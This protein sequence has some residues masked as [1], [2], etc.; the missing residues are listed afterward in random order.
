MVCYTIAST[1]SWSHFQFEKTWSWPNS[2]YY[3]DIHPE[4]ILTK[5]K[6]NIRRTSEN[7]IKIRSRYL[8][9]QRPP[10]RTSLGEDTRMNVPCTTPHSNNGRAIWDRKLPA[11]ATLTTAWSNNYEYN[12][13]VGLP[14]SWGIAGLLT[15]AYS[16][17]I[18]RHLKYDVFTVSVAWM[19]YYLRALRKRNWQHW[20]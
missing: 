4:K 2:R 6:K 3:P 12:W 5:L 16:F 1:V 19:I 8:S 10:R 17:V 18:M 15:T 20:E 7:P 11:W 13:V 9:P 14:A